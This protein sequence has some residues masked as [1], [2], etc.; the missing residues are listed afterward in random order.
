MTQK[1]NRLSV[2]N[3][4]S[5][6]EINIKRKVEGLMIFFFVFSITFIAGLL[7][8]TNNLENFNDS[9]TPGFIPVMNTIV[10]SIGIILF[11]GMIAELLKHES[12]EIKASQL[13]LKNKILGREVNIQKF[14]CKGIKDLQMATPP[15]KGWKK[16]AEYNDT[17]HKQ[18]TYSNDFRKVYPTIHFL[19][20]QTKPYFLPELMKTVT[21]SEVKEKTENE[22]KQEW[23]TIRFGNGLST[24]E[25]LY[26]IELI[27]NPQF[28]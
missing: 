6:I 22:E 3:N 10:G 9:I 5:T 4:G 12:I 2:T 14:D 15:E 13:I 24:E 17:W 18:T 7:Y 20:K 21:N 25:A 8:F 27:K 16:T 28:T 26:I 1:I 19:Y 11:L 23:Q